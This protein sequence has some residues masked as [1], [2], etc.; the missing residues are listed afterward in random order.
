MGTPGG[1]RSAQ[2][3]QRVREDVGDEG[4]KKGGGGGTK[5][6][7]VGKGNQSQEQSLNKQRTW[8]CGGCVTGKRFNK[9]NG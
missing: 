8:P 1:V 7:K 5:V 9:E 2:Q 4:V 6:I 3:P